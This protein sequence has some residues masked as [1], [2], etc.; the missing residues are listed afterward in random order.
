MAIKMIPDACAWVDRTRQISVFRLTVL[1]GAGRAGSLG[2][3]HNRRRI[4]L[5]LGRPAYVRGIS[6]HV[7]VFN[8]T[9]I[10]ARKTAQTY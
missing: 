10:P 5:C 1:P 6:M 9:T 8:G 2:P 4:S 3:H 7:P